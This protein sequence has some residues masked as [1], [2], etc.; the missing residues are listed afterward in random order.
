MR[1]RRVETEA[2]LDRLAACED[3]VGFDRML[4]RARQRCAGQSRAACPQLDGRD[5]AAI[6]RGPRRGQG[7]DPA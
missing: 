4:D 3:Q 5:P 1:A 7:D 6:R 2:E